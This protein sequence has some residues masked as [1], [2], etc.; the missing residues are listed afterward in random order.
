MKATKNL[1]HFAILGLWGIFGVVVILNTLTGSLSVGLGLGYWLWLA[2]FG[3]LTTVGV[4]K[5]E[6]ALGA[7]AVHAG[8]LFVLTLLSARLPLG[9]LRLGI[10]LLHHA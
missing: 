2:G 5:V 8:I 1:A 3:V 10:D 6:S 9:F 4:A 7:L